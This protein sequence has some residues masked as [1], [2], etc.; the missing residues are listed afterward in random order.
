MRHFFSLHTERF[1]LTWLTLTVGKQ[2][3][4]EYFAMEKEERCGCDCTDEI[5]IR[6]SS[7][8]ASNAHG[9]VALSFVYSFVDKSF[10][11]GR[12]LLT[13]LASRPKNGRALSSETWNFLAF[14]TCFFFSLLSLLELMLSWY[15][16][17][18][19]FPSSKRAWL[20]ALLFISGAN[21][22]GGLGSWSFL[23][24]MVG[25][26]R[27]AQTTG[28]TQINLNSW[29]TLWRIAWMH[30]GVV[31][32]TAQKDERRV[33]ARWAYPTLAKDESE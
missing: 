33:R 13:V 20:F 18:F 1:L 5:L 28:F 3:P 19:L 10:Q 9:F 25:V 21:T 7:R 24:S 2:R 23:F 15:I 17:F 22:A 29:N 27:R 31:L 14:L 6:F 12:M 11:G 4:H 30:K 32:T 16:Q 8:Q 26:R